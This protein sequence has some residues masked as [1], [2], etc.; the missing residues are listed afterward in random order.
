M[1]PDPVPD[2][3]TFIVDLQDVNKNF[4]WGFFFANYYFLY[5][6]L[7]TFFKIKSQKE[8]TCKTVG[9]KVLAR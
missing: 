8:V 7:H 4:F 5:V 6:H 2:P 9:I 3:A 1:D